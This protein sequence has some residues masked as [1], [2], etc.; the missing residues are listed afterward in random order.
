MPQA[1][2]HRGQADTALGTVVTKSAATLPAGTTQNIFTVAGGRVWI[3]LLTG[4][5]TTV[6]SATATN[7]SVVHVTTVGGDVTLAS[8]VAIASDEEG[9][10]YGVEGDATA[11]VKFESGAF[12]R[13]ASGG[14]IVLAE[15]T[16]NITTSATNTGA[17]SW[18]MWYIPLDTGATVASA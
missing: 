7:L 1:L 17:T 16:M 10:I 15:G 4:E 9:T 11:L 12:Q 8:T 2:I 13:G 5:V 3:T 6:C 14:G 18:E